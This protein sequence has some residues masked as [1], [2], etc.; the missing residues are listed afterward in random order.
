MN[1]SRWAYL[2]LLLAVASIITGNPTNFWSSH[3][4]D[5]HLDNEYSKLDLSSTKTPEGI[6]STFSDTYRRCLLNKPSDVCEKV[7]KRL[8]KDIN[9]IIERMDEY[10]NA[11]FNFV[12]T[13]E[14][15]KH[16]T[17]YEEFV[18]KGIHLSNPL[19]ED[20]DKCFLELIDNFH[21]YNVPSCYID[22]L[23]HVSYFCDIDSV[24]KCGFLLDYRNI[25][26]DMI[27]EYSP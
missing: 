15:I 12:D 11:M 1:K 6:L 16:T 18:K 5:L 19:L 24:P 14:C 23:L 7:Y 21:T 2:V 10:G 26:S 20:L 17:C 9:V 22:I 25:M 3:S 13:I 4:D 8:V 27:E